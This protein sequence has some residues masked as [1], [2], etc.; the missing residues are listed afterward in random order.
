MDNDNT[1]ISERD[2]RLNKLEELKKLKL[3]PYPAKTC[4]THEI[5]GLID[6]FSELEKTG[7]GIIIAGR[8]MVK[9]LHGNLAFARLNDGS[10][11]IQIAVSKKEVGDEY[12]KIFQKLVDMG[13]I[14]EVAGKCF[15]THKGEK[16]L[17]TAS[18]KFL[19]KALEPLPEKWHGLKDDEDRY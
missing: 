18:F 6:N 8:L 19:T 2:E 5:R 13:D 1:K 11:Q 14:I 17:M 15:T 16:S 7:Q 3:N 10:G 4:R 9:R 12:Y